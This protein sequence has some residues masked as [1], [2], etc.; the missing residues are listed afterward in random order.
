MAHIDGKLRWFGQGATFWSAVLLICLGLFPYPY[1]VFASLLGFLCFCLWQ[2]YTFPKKLLN[3]LHQQGFL[4]LGGLLIISSIFAVNSGEAYLQ[5]AHFLPFFW[6][7][8]AFVSYLQTTSNPWRQ[9]YQWAVILV[10][11]SIPINLVGLVEYALKHSLPAGALTAF[12]GIHWLYIGDFSHPRTFSLF[13][14][15]NTLANYLVMMLGLNIGLLFLQKGTRPI[16]GGLR[17]CQWM[18]YINLPLTLICLYCSGSRNGYLVAAF[19][20]LISIFCVKT[21]RWIRFLGL[22]GIAA[23]VGTTAKF[24][25]GGRSLSWA[26]VT[27][28]PRVEVWRFA[29][30]LT[31]ERPILGHGLGNYKLLYDGEVPG[32]D[33]IAHAHNLWLMLASETGILAAIAFTIIIGL[34]CYRGF[35]G[36]YSLRANPNYYA[37][38]LAYCLSFLGTVLFSLLDV[39]LFEVRVNLLGWLSLAIFYVSPELSPLTHPNLDEFDRT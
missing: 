2:T 17:W 7:W 22:T 9:V 1:C 28:D 5:L 39:T 32:Y 36:L 10:L 11:V 12:P 21:H 15:P 6:M 13:D 38:L 4:I 33:F 30:Q 35:K 23:I 16:S 24:G 37:L 20:L 31:Q 19:L 25:I 18:L 26:W 34:I 3:L 27:S 29:V 8:A 14:Y